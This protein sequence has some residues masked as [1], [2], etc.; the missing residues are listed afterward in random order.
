MNK[1]SL[2]NRFRYAFDNTMAKGITALISWLLLVSVLLVLVLAVIVLIL[3]VLP[4]E[5]F[6]EVF[7]ISVLH[8]LD[9]GM[10]GGDQGSWTFR[11]VMFVIA[12]VG[13]FLV[14]VLIG[15][16]TS[17][18]EDKLTDLR[19]GRSV[20]L[21]QGHT[22]ILGW[23][24]EIFSIIS[25]L[26]IANENQKRS[27]IA[28]L[29]D[30]DKVEMEDEI[31]SKVGSTGRTRVV[32]RTGNPIDLTDLEIVNPH[33]ARA[34]IIPA[35][36]VED[37]DNHTIKTILAITNNPNRHDAPYHV[38]AEIRQPENLRVA[39]MVGKEEVSLILTDDLI[40]RITVQA[41]LQSGLSVV[42]T[43]LIDF[44]GDEIYFQE[45]PAVV[46][47]TFGDV[48][49]MYEAS[50][51]IGLAYPDGHIAI[52]PPMDTMVAAGAELIAVSAD[53]DTVVLSN[54][55]SEIDS[56]ALRSPE[57]VTIIPVRVMVLGWNRRT[58]MVINELDSYV[59]KGSRITIVAGAPEA[60]SRI[61]EE[62]SDLKNAAIEF[63]SGDITSRQTLDSLNLPAYQHV[64]LLNNLPDHDP[65]KADAGTL[66]TLLHL[67]DIAEK[68]RG[69]YSIATEMLEVQNRDLAVVARADDFIVSSKLVSLMLSQIS[70]NKALAKVFETLFSVEGSELYLKPVDDYVRTDREVNFYTVVEAARRKGQVAIGYRVRRE[71]HDAGRSYGVHINPVK[72]HIVRFDHEDKIIVLAE[73]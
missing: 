72:S 40:S 32:C 58:P 48:L 17:G 54:R 55:K 45:E 57:H 2:W 60:E 62:C 8:A 4:G 20:V 51:V 18:I 29:A 37:P 12:L 34:I 36:N 5:S 46:G 42:I 50:A 39:K 23:G 15:V 68:Q 64:I 16:I 49:S 9:P 26:V 52:N 38:V 35:P 73:H 69:G 63:V 28:I 10:I 61:R 30:K 21:E 65:Q 25:E 24:P 31:R 13:L 33:M 14:S 22:V 67:R 6:V 66:V 27:C 53:D 11:L 47:K 7:W 1:P 44:G 41:S 3:Q 43:E 19:K 56:S 59:H 70:E 71:E